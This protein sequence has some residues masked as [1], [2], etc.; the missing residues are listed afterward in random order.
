M[1]T[2]MR[3]RPAAQRRAARPAQPASPSTPAQLP[4]LVD[5]ELPPPFFADA[6]TAFL[7]LGDHPDQA[8]TPP[9]LPP[10][11]SAEERLAQALANLPPLPTV[12]DPDRVARLLEIYRTLDRI[13]G[14]ACAELQASA[15]SV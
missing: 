10:M 8:S 4:P 5:D 15:G 9:P 14:D 12:D 3:T 13:A 6:D 7:D 1:L 11:L 2:W